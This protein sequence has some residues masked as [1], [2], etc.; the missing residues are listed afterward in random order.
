[1]DVTNESLN[2]AIEV[3]GPG[4]PFKGIAKVIREVIGDKPFSVCS[5]FTGHGI[6]TVFHRP[7]WILHDCM[8]VFVDESKSRE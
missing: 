7:P 5:Q 6:G 2:A 4:R 3:C 1:M 8:L